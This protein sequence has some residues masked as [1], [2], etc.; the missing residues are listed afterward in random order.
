MPE[1]KP[2]YFGVIGKP[3]IQSLSPIIHKEALRLAGLNGTYLRLAV[4]SLK[5]ALVCAKEMGL[6]GLN[7]TSPFKEEVLSEELNFNREVVQVGAA[8]TLV[9]GEQTWAYN[10]D[11][12]GVLQSLG[13]SEERSDGK[14][15]LII[16]AGGAAKAAAYALK[17]NG[18]RVFVCNRSIEKAQ[19]LA[20]QL[21][22][23]P[24]SNE[25]AALLLKNTD[26]LVNTVFATESLVDLT[27]LQ[28]H[29]LILDAI[30]AKQT[31]FSECCSKHLNYIDGKTWLFNQGIKAFELFTGF[32]TS[33]SQASEI[34]GSLFS[35]VKSPPRTISLIGM[36]GSGK[37]SVGSS[38][39]SI[40]GDEFVDLDDVVE[41]VAGCTIA[42]LISEQGEETF[43][44]L[45][46]QCLEQVL[47]NAPR[48]LSCGGG[49][50]G[51][52]TNRALLQEQTIP[53][54]LWASKEELSKRLVRFNHRPLLLGQD[55]PSRVSDL[56][57]QRF[58][59][60]AE[61]SQ[62]VVTTKDKTI[63]EIAKRIAFEVINVH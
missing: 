38:L 31:S 27:H 32:K 26:Y 46:S 51:S 55:L 60:Y 43:R 21:G 37:S 24:I 2:V 29:T 22:I 19:N 44:Q 28:S 59:Q 42:K 34:R 35:E 20:T 49:I 14:T 63:T 11:L 33:P 45:E 18:C 62:L 17:T 7:I 58:A 41:Q 16:G 13:L 5:E 52:A 4:D 12:F 53:V 57:D 8:N 15:A 23:N 6:K 9:F 50:I 30:Y 54:W 1:I 10:T 40:L 48:V 36:M 39:S 56:V 47:A 25:D 3:I 61:V